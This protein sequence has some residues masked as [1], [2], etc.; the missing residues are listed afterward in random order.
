M[1]PKPTKKIQPFI[2]FLEAMDK[3]PGR[4]KQVLVSEPIRRFM[5][6]PPFGTIVRGTQVFEIFTIGSFKPD[7]FLYA[8]VPHQEHMNR[9]AEKHVKLN[10]KYDGSKTNPTDRGPS[11]S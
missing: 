3:L 6:W 2:D 11:A 8:L 4:V 7:R 5:D 1:T 9:L 10:K